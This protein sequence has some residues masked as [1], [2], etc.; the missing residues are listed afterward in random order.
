MQ[1]GH[2]RHWP[3]ARAATPALRKALAGDLDNIVLKALAKRP[4]QRYPSVE[5]LALDLQRFREG[6]PVQAR[7]QSV[8]Y[9]TRK[10]LHRHRWALATVLLVTLVLSTALGIVAWQARQ[11][12][13]EA[14]RAQALQDFVVGLFEHAGESSNGRL[15]VRQLLEAGARRGTSELARQPAARAELFG[16]IARLRLGLG[17]YREA[18]QLLNQQA[19]II[20]VLGEDAP[21]GLRLQSVTDRGRAQRTLGQPRLCI[22]AMRRLAPL[23]QRVQQQLPLQVAEFYSQLGRCRRDAGQAASARRLFERALALRGEP[24][25]DGV[26]ASENM[27][28]LAGL[29]NDAGDT[30]KALRGT[31][32]ALAKLRASAGPRQPFA[33][34]LLRTQC[35]LERSAGAVDMAARDC[36][37]ALALAL[38][39]HG[40][41]YPTAI[42]ARRQ[43]AAILVDQGHLG[44][45]E[46]AYRDTR[47]WL[48]ARVGP[49]HASVAKDDNSLGIIAWERGDTAAALRWLDQS[50]AIRRAGVGGSSPLDLSGV[51][52][53]KA[54]VLHDS[55]D[56]A[57]ARPLLAET[58]Q[59]RAAALRADHPLVG[60]TQRLLGEV[61]AGLG[62]RARARGELRSAVDLT[63]N[64]YGYAHPHTRRAELSLAAFDAATGDATALHRLDQLAQLPA[65]DSELR[66]VAWLATGDA[67]AVRCHGARQAQALSSFETLDRQVREAQP[68]GGVI[69]RRLAAMH[70]ACA[71]G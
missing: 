67:A 5:A 64:G 58:L 2:W 36:R 23:A 20:A 33:V 34:D 60:D 40:A 15:D 48:V 51:L 12:V 68:E 17:D 11:A 44:E 38:S 71:A 29:D 39:L 45:A 32:A 42:D 47:A 56:D 69:A 43:L 4:E 59:L 19:S 13:Q 18:L 30:A 14:S 53:N 35:A 21:P 54:M 16:V 7:P 10:Y 1:C 3:S 41:A 61:D 24:L 57:S 26:G 31:R 28:D 22:D 70:A 50:I 63:R 55:G 37:A 52:F 62:D 66:K 27:A 8:R 65:A 25:N 9:R 46:A 49:T 6:K